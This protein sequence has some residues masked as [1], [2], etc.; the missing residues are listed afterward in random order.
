MLLS[1]IKQSKMKE[2]EEFCLSCYQRDQVLLIYLWN[3]LCPCCDFQ[4]EIETYVEPELIEPELTEP[5]LTEPEILIEMSPSIL[6]DL[7]EPVP[8]SV[9]SDEDEDE[10]LQR[11]KDCS[12]CQE[13]LLNQ[14]GHIHPGGCLFSEN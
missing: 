9:D 8:G 10:I 14:L 2:Q 4:E 3:N 5:E 6:V 12:G 1:T 7:T 13:G 11:I